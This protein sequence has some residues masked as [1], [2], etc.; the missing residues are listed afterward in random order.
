VTGRTHQLRVHC[1][2]MGFPILGDTIYGTAR[3]LR[4]EA[5]PLHLHSRE[6]AVPLY[7]NR[8][9]IRVSAPVPLAMQDRL[10]ACGWQG[11]VFRLV[12]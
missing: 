4:T 7:R 9:P 2:A 12:D 5:P 3:G 11:E 1:A 6:V 8:E 10:Y